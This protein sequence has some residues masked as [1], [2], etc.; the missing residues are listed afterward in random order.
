MVPGSEAL[1]YRRFLGRYGFL[2]TGVLHARTRLPPLGA[3][4][5]TS[6]IRNGSDKNEVFFVFEGETFLILKGC[7]RPFLTFHLFDLFGSN[8]QE[9]NMNLVLFSTVLSC[10]VYKFYNSHQPTP[11]KFS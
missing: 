5:G 6:L 4:R 7:N 10:M 9:I 11:M 1:L 2:R 8:P 3:Y